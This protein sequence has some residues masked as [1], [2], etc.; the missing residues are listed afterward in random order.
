MREEVI[1]AAIIP[2]VMKV[3]KE[4]LNVGDSFKAIILAKN[5]IYSSFQ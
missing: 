4:I 2:I 3:N 5:F 1:L